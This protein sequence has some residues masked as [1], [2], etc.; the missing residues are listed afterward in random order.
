MFQAIFLSLLIPSFISTNILDIYVKYNETNLH[1]L[2]QELSSCGSLEKPFESLLQAFYFVDLNSKEIENTYDKIKILLISKDYVID[3]PNAT[4]YLTKLNEFYGSKDGIWKIFGRFTAQN[5]GLELI[6]Y[7]GLNKVR[8][9]FRTFLISFQVNFNY[10]AFSGLSFFGDDFLLMSSKGKRCLYWKLACCS[11]CATCRSNLQYSFLFGTIVFYH[12]FEINSLGSAFNLTNCAFFNFE[13]RKVYISGG[14]TYTMNGFLVIK[15]TQVFISVNNCIFQNILYRNY[16]FGTLDID[17]NSMYFTFYFKRNATFENCSMIKINHDRMVLFNANATFEFAKMG[18]VKL[19][20]CN[21]NTVLYFLNSVNLHNLTL[22]NCK[23]SCEILNDFSVRDGYILFASS[24]FIYIYDCYFEGDFATS[25]ILYIFSSSLSV[26][27]LKMIDINFN[28]EYAIAFPGFQAIN[29]FKNV[30]ITLMNEYYLTSN[31]ILFSE[32]S[33]TIIEN[34]TFINLRKEST[35]IFNFNLDYV[36]AHLSEG[37]SYLC[38]LIKDVKVNENDILFGKIQFNF[39]KGTRNLIVIHNFIGF[40]ASFV[41]S[42]NNNVTVSQSSFQSHSNQLLNMFIADSFNNFIFKFCSFSSAISNIKGT[43]FN[44][45]TFNSITFLNCKFSELKNFESA[46]IIYAISF[47]AIKFFNSFLSS[48]ETSDNG[49]GCLL[50]DNNFLIISNSSVKNYSTINSGGFLYAIQSKNMIKIDNSVFESGYAADGGSLFLNYQSFLYIYKSNFS[51]NSA[52]FDGGTFKFNVQ[53]TVLIFESV[54]NYSLSRELSGAISIFQQNKIKITLSEISNSFANTGGVFSLKFNNSFILENSSLKFAKARELAGCFK[55]VNNNILKVF[56]TSFEEIFSQNRGGVL[57]L[58]TKNKILISNSNFINSFSYE[59]VFLIQNSNYFL[60]LSSNFN[61]KK[62]ILISKF[63]NVEGSLNN[64]LIYDI[65]RFNISLS[66]LLYLEEQNQIRLESIYFSNIVIKDYLIISQFR[67]IIFVNKLN[68]ISL[69]PGNSIIFKIDKSFLIVKNSNFVSKDRNQ[70]LFGIV[71]ISKA[72][73]INNKIVNKKKISL[74]K[75]HLNYGFVSYSSLL[76]FHKLFVTQND[77]YFNCSYVIFSIFTSL[78]LQNS[79]AINFFPTKDKHYSSTLDLKIFKSIFWR[80]KGNTQG[81]VIYFENPNKNENKILI[82]KSVFSLNRAIHGSVLHCVNLYKLIAQR[83]KFAQ[84]YAETDAPN[85]IFSKG[86]VFYLRTDSNYSEYVLNNNKIYLNKACLGGAF[87]IKNGFPFL[88][89]NKILKK[90]IIKNNIAFS[91]GN[92]FATYPFII[93]SNFDEKTQPKT[94]IQIKN[95]VSGENYDYCLGM[96]YFFDGYGNLALNNEITSLNNDFNINIMTSK[97]MRTEE[98]QICFYG[99]LKLYSTNTSQIYD[100]K[101]IFSY[102]TQNIGIKSSEINIFYSF[103]PCEKGETMDSAFNCVKCPRSFYS[104]QTKVDISTSCIACGEDIGFN[105]FGGSNITIKSGY[106]RSSYNS[107]KILACPNSDSC[108]GDNRIFQVGTIYEDRFAIQRCMKGYIDP[109]CAVCDKGYGIYDRY[110]CLKCDTLDY[111]FRSICFFFLQ[112]LVCT[113]TVYK[114]FVMSINI[115]DRKLDLKNMVSTT[116]LKLS[117]NH[118]QLLLILFSK[119]GGWKTFISSFFDRNPFNS[120]FSDSL[121]IQCLFQLLNLNIPYLYSKMIVS[122]ITPIFLFVVSVSYLKIYLH[123]SRK[124]TKKSHY[125]KICKKIGELSLFQGLFYVIF[126]IQTSNVIRDCFSMF[127]FANIE[128]EMK[129]KD[130]RL[131]LDYAVQYESS[132]HTKMTNFL[133]LPVIL[134]VGVAFPVFIFFRIYFKKIN[135]ILQT[136]HNLF[137]YGYFFYPYKDKFYFWDMI[138]AFQKFIVQGIVVMSLDLDDERGIKTTVAILMFF[139]I[140]SY[141]LLKVKP[142]KKEFNVLNI[143]AGKSFLTLT[144]STIIMIPL[145]ENKIEFLLK[146]DLFFLF[147]LIFFCLLNGGFFIYTVSIYLKNLNFYKKILSLAKSIDSKIFL[148]I[149]SSKISEKSGGQQ[150]SQLTGFSSKIL[151]SS[152]LS[153][154]KSSGFINENL[155]EETHLNKKISRSKEIDLSVYLK[156]KNQKFDHLLKFVND[157]GIKQKQIQKNIKCFNKL[158]GEFFKLCFE[159]ENT[160]CFFENEFFMLKLSFS[161]NEYRKPVN[162]E[163]VIN[164][165]N[166]DVT[167]VRSKINFHE[168]SDTCKIKGNRN[169][170][171]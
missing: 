40:R 107:T 118:S 32:Q 169:F 81:G 39:L 94:T 26:I 47:N 35:L 96:I 78:I 142:Y 99:L 101:L 114:S 62:E 168:N 139:V 102:Y 80:I 128:D 29:I 130:L 115:C 154:I 46:S 84:N 21:F 14:V 157:A 113:Y 42:Q 24:T 136:P 28:D 13:I 106:W 16:F 27:N 134:L 129:E 144:L 104:F 61:F 9:H 3:P 70:I 162:F 25:K 112:I 151:K 75:I 103:R 79:V 127:L 122:L 95:L 167:E 110:V 124:K 121:S 91:Y 43:I 2:E 119:K 97:N 50:V 19:A 8:I 123:F 147:L 92:H 149:I 161:F 82:E 100:S 153:K 23:F 20:N 90:N 66:S 49:G 17:Q 87:Y 143:A 120:N 108:N 56:S 6:S 145:F 11:C 67:N 150:S 60:C 34:C 133:S 138:N 105:C 12:I 18:Y 44:L 152:N 166:S 63:L 52:G 158:G 164:V 155:D 171:F 41:F 146:E 132:L 55:I 64:I 22:I 93:S 74:S 98:G 71:N 31:A 77:F 88:D 38:L 69:T 156:R 5:L 53:I 30:L 125:G 58:D 57:T 160:I 15:V 73:F 126:T 72:F 85:N 165:F 65:K 170:F 59:D 109:L 4:Y 54:I 51:N 37:E 45:G 10:F 148:K 116:L 86:G 89:K 76:R 68:I 135:Y 111:L 7:G 33:I 131:V 163:I 141:F 140:S 1:C 36:S 117:I 83:S 159:K 137:V 48:F